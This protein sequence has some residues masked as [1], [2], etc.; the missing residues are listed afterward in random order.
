MVVAGIYLGLSSPF[1]AADGFV[2]IFARSN[3]ERPLRIRPYSWRGY[4]VWNARSEKLEDAN[5]REVRFPFD[6]PK[7]CLFNVQA[8]LPCQLQ[9]IVFVFILSLPPF[10]R[11]KSSSLC[12]LRRVTV[13]E[14][15]L[16]DKR[17][18]GTSLASSQYNNHPLGFPNVVRCSCCWPIVTGSDKWPSFAPTR[19]LLQHTNHAYIFSYRPPSGIITSNR[20]LATPS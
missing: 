4:A 9:C 5:R 18:A 12:S 7:Y 15:R 19:P 14:H 13:D 2:K 10:L 17:A 3:H 11:G 16:N 6:L 20:S 8:T 1:F